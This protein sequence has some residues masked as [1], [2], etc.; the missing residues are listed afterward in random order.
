MVRFKLSR[1]QC[2]EIEER[3]FPYMLMSEKM[4]LRDARMHEYAFFVSKMK[5]S[6]L[7]E[8]IITFKRK[9]LTTQDKFLFKFSDH[10]GVCFYQFLNV[11]PIDQTRVYDVRLRQI[12]MEALHKQLLE[13]HDDIH[14]TTTT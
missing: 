7:N 11:Q 1:D 14:Q 12:L 6:M 5:L 10:T 3:F 4:R 9:L 13:Y 2:R 8:I